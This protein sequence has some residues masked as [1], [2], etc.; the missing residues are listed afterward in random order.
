[1]TLRYWNVRVIFQNVYDIIYPENKHTTTYSKIYNYMDTCKESGLQTPP[2]KSG[3][4]VCNNVFLF[5][6]FTI[7]HVCQHLHCKRKLPW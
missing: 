7:K 5:M 3:S 6:G 4:H 2:T 1:M